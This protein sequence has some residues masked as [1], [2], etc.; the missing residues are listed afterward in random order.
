M[1][2]YLRYFNN[3]LNYYSNIYGVNFIHLLIIAI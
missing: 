3:S 1:V 2:K